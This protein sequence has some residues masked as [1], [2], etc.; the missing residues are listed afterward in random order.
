[1]TIYGV[2]ILLYL[3]LMVF[4]S[5]K[6]GKKIKSQEDFSVAG[7]SLPAAVVFLT[8]L[9]TWTGTGSI[10]GNAEKIYQVGIAA[11]I[12]PLG[13]LIG[14]ALLVFLAGR[15]RDL[16]QITVQDILEKRFSVW[17]RIFG[18]VALVIAAVTIVSYQY[19]ACG[20]VLNLA[21]PGLSLDKAIL[22]SVLFVIL[23]TAVAGMYSVAYTDVVMGATMLVGMAVALVLF[24]SKAGGI[25]GAMRILPTQHARLFGPIGWV[26]SLGL[27]L[28]PMLLA[29]GDANMYQRFFSAKSAGVAKKAT[30][31]TLLGV[32]FIDLTI[33]AT[34][35]FC[36][37]LEWQGGQLP[38]PG[39]VIAYAARDFL[40]PL[41]GAVLLTAILAIIVS[42][43][44]GYLLVPTTSLVRDIYQR[45]INP[46]ASQIS[47]VWISRAT[48]VVLGFMA[49]WISTLSRQFL[50]VALYAYTI[51][52][53]AIT[54]SL[55]AALI[56]KRATKEGAISSILGGT[57]MTFYWELSGMAASTGVDTVLPAI[58]VSVAL[59]VSVSLTRIPPN[60][61]SSRSQR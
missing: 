39:R 36:S 7:R 57:L 16:E 51:Y 45:F 20:A 40:P 10:F 22:I 17:A 26:E 41:L 27:L 46:N 38:I 47:I 54:P 19:R 11:L 5:F 15:A 34:A 32:A 53:A 61:W 3:L 55:V 13:E 44:I 35:W 1:M 30:L 50:S 58:G 29:L 56:W 28:P 31:W 60:V 59:L 52:G 24:W 4:V 25:S 23:Y 2:V 9:A 18:T 37:A 48:V 33:I 6:Y 12:L 21:V 8:M 43:A 49:Y 42:T 14:I